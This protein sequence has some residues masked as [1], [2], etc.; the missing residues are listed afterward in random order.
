MPSARSKYEVRHPKEGEQR[1]Y[2]PEDVEDIPLIR[3]KLAPGDAR[4]SRSHLG[5]QG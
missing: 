4:H 5:T 2:G 1:F 3:T